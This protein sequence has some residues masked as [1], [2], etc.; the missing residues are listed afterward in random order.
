[1]LYVSPL[2]K[3]TIL[4]DGMIGIVSAST[5]GRPVIPR[6]SIIFAPVMDAFVVNESNPFDLVPA[7]ISAE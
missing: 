2:F 1:M 7:K 6:R 5:D 3:I 4:P